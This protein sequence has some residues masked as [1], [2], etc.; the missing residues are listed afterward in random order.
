MNL[1][2]AQHVLFLEPVM[3]PGEEAQA[4]GR[5]DRMGQTRDTFI[6]KFTFC[7]SIEENVCR[8]NEEKKLH[9]NRKSRHQKTNHLSVSE[10]A[11]LLE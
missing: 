5:V 3:D 9:E 10:V 8:I 2:Q 1:Q 11:M 4:V 6:H 7:H